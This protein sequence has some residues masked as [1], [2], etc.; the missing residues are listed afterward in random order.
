MPTKSL[1]CFSG[2]ACLRSRLRQLRW[3]SV[4]SSG[5]SIANSFHRLQNE[6]YTGQT[7]KRQV[8]MHFKEKETQGEY[9]LRLRCG[10]GADSAEAHRRYRLWEPGA[11]ACPQYAR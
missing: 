2:P 11:R 9:L 3:L 8:K 6:Q 10:S 7:L 1:T 4:P 5:S